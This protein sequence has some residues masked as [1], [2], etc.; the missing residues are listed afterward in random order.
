GADLPGTEPRKVVAAG[1]CG[2]LGAGVRRIAH[3]VVVG[4]GA[5]RLD[6]VGQALLFQPVPQDTFGGGRTADVSGA[7]E[8]DLQHGLAVPWRSRRGL[9]TDAGPPVKARMA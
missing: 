8:E 2:P 3:V 1:L 5:Q 7:D 9:L 6:L 4:P